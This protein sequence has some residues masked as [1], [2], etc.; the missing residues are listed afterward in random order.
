MQ[1]K[2]ALKNFPSGFPLMPAD[3]PPS[4]CILALPLHMRIHASLKAVDPDV[5]RAARKPKHLS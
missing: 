1:A 5:P 4:F 3:T 2:Q